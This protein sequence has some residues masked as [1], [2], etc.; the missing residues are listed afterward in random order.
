MPRKPT[1]GYYVKG[2]FVAQGSELDQ[3]F[4]AQRKGGAQVSKTERKREVSALQDLGEDLLALG[5]GTLARLPLPDSLRDA[6][7][8]A[9]RTPSFEGKRRQMQY[10][11]KLMRRLDAAQ[12][13]AARAALRAQ[14]GGLVRESALLHQSEQWRERLVAE[15]A[16]LAL[17]LVQFPHTD[18]QQL[19]ALIRQARKDREAAAP[20]LPGA[21]VRQGRAW[22][23]LYQLVRAGLESAVQ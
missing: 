8:Q 12:I 10:I 16:A 23:A 9:R 13:E 17:W 11:G 3:Q 18:G 2:Q 22:R 5:S 6:L 7:E 19:R 20:P 15:P 4:Q 21:A 14:R 1:K